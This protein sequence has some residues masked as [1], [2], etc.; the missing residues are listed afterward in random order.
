[1]VAEE[2]IYILETDDFEK[3]EYKPYDTTEEKEEDLP[4]LKY[5]LDKVYLQ[6]LDND[7]SKMLVTLYMD[8]GY[9]RPNCVKEM[10][11]IDKKRRFLS[12]AQGKC[13]LRLFNADLYEIAEI[14]LKHSSE[15]RFHPVSAAPQ[16]FL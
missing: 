8:Y 6:R 11:I 1:M 10:V 12:Q 15:F 2:N 13:I 16:L 14:P 7:P 3:V 4:K 5:V 9:L